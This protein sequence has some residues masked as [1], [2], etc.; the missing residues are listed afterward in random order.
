MRLRLFS[1]IIAL[2][3]PLVLQASE[4][5]KVDSTKVY[6]I[7]PAMVAASRMQLPLKNI[8]Q[9]VEIIDKSLLESAPHENLGE[10]LKRTINLDIIQ[11]PGA[12]TTVGMR[13]FSPTAHSRN[14]TLL[15]IDGQ[16]AGTNNLTTIPTDFIE[17]VEVVKGPYSLL[18]GSDAMGGV[19]NVITKRSSAA[20]AVNVGLSGGS[21]AQTNYT[22][23]VSGAIAP[24][25]LLA[26]GFSLKSQDA[27]YRIGSKN[28]LELSNVE[29][30]I[31]DEKSY[32]DIMTHTKYRIND[33]N[34]KLEYIINN[35]WSAQLYSSATLAN[36]VQT[37]GNYWHSYG[38]SKKDITRFANYL[39]I[40]NITANNELN[41]A[42][43]LTIQQDAN[44]DSKKADAAFINSRETIRGCGVKVGNTHTWGNLKWLL[45]VDL[46][47]YDVTSKRYSEKFTPTAPYR[48]DNSRLSVSGFTQLAYNLRNLSLN[49]GVRYDA[50][51]YTL[52]ASSLLGSEKRSEFYSH[53][54]PSLGVRYYP[55]P[56]LSLHGS[57]GSAFYV[58][59]AYKTAGSYMIGKVKYVGN[60]DLKPEKTT[61]FDVGVSYST[62]G[63]LSMDLTYF[64]NFYSDKIINDNSEKGV[65]TYKNA[66]KGQMSGLE[67][68]LSWDVARLWT[69][70]YILKLYTGVTY[71]LKNDF[72][73]VSPSK[74]TITKK[75]LYTRDATANVSLVFN[76][77]TGFE[78]RLSGRYI[79][80][81]LENDWMVWGNLR[82]AIKP[83][84]YYAEGGYTTKDQILRHSAHIV[85]DFSSYY[86]FKNRY[87]VG[88]SVSNLLDEN[89]TEKDGYNMPGRS[90]MGHFVFQL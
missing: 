44:Y 55:L 83:D 52:Q 50:I 81:R 31:L 29:K 48:P 86:T 7:D 9:K 88:I 87:K 36:D 78:A 8:P 14:Y 28:L 54:S 13:G 62:G 35:R 11:Y 85:V 68:M 42:P 69:R 5:D 16:P 21:F 38:M 63:L 79:G 66:G 82:P 77:T 32:G 67:F 34:G 56:E 43:Y 10:I 75:S 71:M 4:L 27:D 17:R 58:P 49:G 64:Q 41:I 39:Q 15:L 19:I 30:L 46:D 73:D 84:D 20:T 22:G 61:S 18:Y 24:K 65:T 40:N 23:F 74:P 59:D 12:L 26:M 6:R 3:L 33:F 2:A 80:S 57:L 37:P 76:N 51:Q 1:G 72:E 60:K 53:L 89:Y 25:L 47:S 70:S 90:V 45:G